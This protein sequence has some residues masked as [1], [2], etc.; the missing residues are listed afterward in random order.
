MG[1]GEGGGARGRG[2][3]REREEIFTKK[4]FHELPAALLL[5]ESNDERNTIL[6]AHSVLGHLGIRV[7][8]GD[9][10]QGADCSIND[11][12]TSSSIRDHTKKSL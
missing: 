2:T 6:L 9:V 7:A 4:G 5:E 8:T 10:P 12:L 1:G 3:E 11:F